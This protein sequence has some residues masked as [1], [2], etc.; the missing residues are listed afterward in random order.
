MRYEQVFIPR[1]PSDPK[2][3]RLCIYRPLKPSGNKTGLLW[4][5]GGGYALSLPEAE[6][7]Y[8][9]K[10]VLGFGLTVVAPDYRLSIDA[11]YPAALDD[12]YSAIC[13]MNEHADELGIDRDKIAVGGD[14]AGGGLTAALSIYARDKGE[15]PIAWQM[16]FY[17]MIDDR[18]ITPSSQDNDA[19]VWDTA[20]NTQA[21]KLY[22]GELYGTD[23]VPPYAAPARL[24]DF[25]GLPP[26][27][28]FVGSIDPFR[29]ETVTYMENLKAA[30]V[31]A[32]YKVFDG[33]FHAF[34]Q[35]AS[36]SS[37]AREAKSMMSAF[38]RERCEIKDTLRPE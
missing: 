18:M 28:T 37:P 10:F 19:P 16:P 8:Y 30:G 31:P 20:S 12:C 33:C 15:V 3:L 23:N 6:E 13:W 34:D 2:P 25:H 38:I 36:K 5:H 26:A 14:S 11:P 27:F 17:P 24:K 4:M 1:S 7:F 35:M 21:W 22:L 9:R 29:D 32:E